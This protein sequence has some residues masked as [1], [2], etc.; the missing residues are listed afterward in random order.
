[1]KLKTVYQTILS[2]FP[3]LCTYFTETLCI[4]LNS[5]LNE[6]KINVIK[7]V[8]TITSILAI[9]PPP[10]AKPY[11]LQ[12]NFVGKSNDQ[13]FALCLCDKIIYD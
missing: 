7:H 11:F 8:F 4:Q 3:N 1:M 5:E 13:N 6:T 10:M 9:I 12:N 2:L